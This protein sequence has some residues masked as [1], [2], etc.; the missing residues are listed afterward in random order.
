MLTYACCAW[1]TLVWL[2]GSPPFLANQALTRTVV[3]SV[4]IAVRGGLTI[5]IIEADGPLPLPTSGTVDGPPR[6]YLDLIGVTPRSAGLT[7]LPGGGS[8][9]GVR[10]ALNAIDPHV[11][12]VVL[13][14]TQP[15]AF[16]IN[17]E[18]LESGRLGIIFGTE[19][20]TARDAAAPAATVPPPAATFPGS[21]TSSPAGALTAPPALAAP[22]GTG[23]VTEAQLA[24][25]AGLP[26]PAPPNPARRNLPTETVIPDLRLPPGE[27]EA[28][29]RQL[30]SV[31]ERIESRRRVVESI[32]KAEAVPVEVLEFT[33]SEFRDLRRILGA[34][35]PSDALRTTHDLLAVSCNLAS[36]AT[37]L[38]IEATRHNDAEA[39]RN[40][41][42]AAAGA[43]ML[44]DRA[45]A[46]L[47][48][49]GSRR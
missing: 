20:S 36:T 21:S 38:Q 17:T 4:Q 42:S 9:R 27:A 45:C 43:L 24:G 32:D 11:T 13:D 46:R 22:P 49:A 35:K 31:L 6:I 48:C 44:L 41:P 16:R 18:E 8:V 47:D 5:A 2:T 33:A 25:G 39:R 34:F 7:R 28:Y 40:A 30:Q 15:T 19:S 3:R 26:S 1:L 29:R 12:R 37:S 23:P 14:L 10:M